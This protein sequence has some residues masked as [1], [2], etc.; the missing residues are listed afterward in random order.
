M[1]GEELRR[2]RR[3]AIIT[4]D[5]R[6]RY[7]SQAQCATWVGVSR[8]SWHRMEQGTKPVPKWLKIIVR[9]HTSIT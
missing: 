9:T 4:V 6:L 1:T 8:R 7:A 5:G 2:W 3:A